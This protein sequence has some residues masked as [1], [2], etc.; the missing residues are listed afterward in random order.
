MTDS[1]SLFT[2]LNLEDETICVS[3]L[4]ESSHNHGFP[5]PPAETLPTL[6]QLARGILHVR[7]GIAA[8]IQECGARA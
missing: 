7:A 5:P 3:P 6:E 1:R 8:L 2:I 4:M